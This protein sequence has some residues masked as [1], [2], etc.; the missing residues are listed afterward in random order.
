MDATPGQVTVDAALSFSKLGFPW[1][2]NPDSV[3]II[4]F[5]Q[6]KPT[7]IMSFSYIQ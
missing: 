2:Q 3:W 1:S 5:W 6:S 7:C 4:A